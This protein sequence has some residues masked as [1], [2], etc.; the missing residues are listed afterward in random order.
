MPRPV[1][2]ATFLAGLLILSPAFP[3]VSAAKDKLAT[4]NQ[5]AHPIFEQNGGFGFCLAEQF[6]DNGRSLAFALSPHGKINVGVM[7]PRAGFVA[8]NQYD[9]TLSLT[10]RDSPVDGKSYKRAVRA[11]AIDANS[12]VLQMGKNKAFLRALTGANG[13]SVAAAGNNIHFELPPMDA[14]LEDLERCNRKNKGVVN[15]RAAEAEKVMPIALEALLI[16][17]GLKNIAPL[18]L[19]DIPEN[20]RPADHMWKTGHLMGGVRER[21]A[22]ADKNLEELIGLYVQGL[23]SR[24]DGTFNAEVGRERTSGG[25]RLRPADV[26]CRMKM[27]DTGKEETVIGAILFYLTPANKF[28][29]FTHETQ[30]AHKKEATAARD[31]LRDTILRLAKEANKKR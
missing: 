13:L 1:L 17:A 15:P 6:A 26:R 30:P 16:E 23:K 25:L 7:I 10:Q 18:N 22:P 8:G 4:K 24:C 21:L 19:D 3:A 9:L 14:V 5:D 12:L 27:P 31:A 11:V 20:Q 2:L 29:I 28:A